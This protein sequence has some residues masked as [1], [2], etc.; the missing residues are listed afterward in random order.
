MVSNDYSHLTDPVFPYTDSNNIKTKNFQLWIRGR[1][2]IEDLDEHKR[3]SNDTSPV[4][5]IECPSSADVVFKVGTS[6]VSHP[7]NA[8]FRDLLYAYHDE[9]FKTRSLV[10]K[11]ETAAKIIQD[12]ER[13]HG[14][15]LEWNKSGCWVVIHEVEKFFAKICTS[16]IYFNKT[17]NAKKNMQVSSSSTFLFERQDGKKRKREPDGTEPSGCTKACS[18]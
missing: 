9:F 7:G 11:Q 5:L 17:V 2:A 3:N 18:F 10:L 16:M 6:N 4:R 1:K 14:R 15:L 8:A 12:V 13:R